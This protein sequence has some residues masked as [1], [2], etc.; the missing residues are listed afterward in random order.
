MQPS[1]PCMTSQ[2]AA[3]AL[4]WL[5]VIGNFVSQSFQCTL[6][7]VRGSVNTC[8]GKAWAIARMKPLLFLWITLQSYAGI[9]SD[10]YFLQLK[11]CKRFW[12]C[13]IASFIFSLKCSRIQIIFK[14]K[15]ESLMLFYY[16]TTCW[17]LTPLHFCFL[18]A[19]ENFF[20]LRAVNATAF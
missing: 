14:A 11:D 10:L 18:T 2:H 19:E 5:F 4:N 7:S 17:S 15:L 16:F 9:I 8:R 13:K 3:I 1:A 20:T 6:V 12:F